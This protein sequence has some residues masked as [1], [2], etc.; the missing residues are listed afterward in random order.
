MLR[1]DAL[2]HPL[3]LHVLEGMHEVSEAA[4]DRLAG[5]QP[6]VTHRFLAALEHTGCVSAISGW[7]PQHITL[8]QG[9]DLVAA[10]PMY[11]K[12]HSY[13]EYVFDWAWAD[14]Y[15]TH[16]LEYYPKL[17]SAIPFT[18]VTGPRLLAT[19]D[20][21]KRQLVDMAI[22]YAE[23]IGASSFHCLFPE[24][25]DAEIL[26]N[27]GLLMRQGI[28]FHWANPGYGSFNDY[29]AA[30][31]HD[32]RKKIRQERRKSSAA[33]IR[34]RWL[35]GH[36]IT[37]DLWRFFT[38]CYHNTY[39]EHR[40]RP[41]LNLQCFERF[42]ETLAPHMVLI[43]AEEHG[44]SIA[45]AL[46]ILDG[47]KLYGRYWGAMNYRPG[48]HFE[49]CYYQAIE[50]CIAHGIETFE[51][52]AQGEHKLARGL[53]PVPTTSAHWLAHPAFSDA[54]DRYLRQEARGIS[55]YIDELNERQPF[56]RT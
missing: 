23:T 21:L 10:M 28:Q 52:G 31:N 3:T 56:K 16:G 4:W 40:A 33:G 41:Y 13:G 5:T 34:F 30:M 20:L 49:T 48:L 47:K 43:V 25:D 45:A 42:G 53:L 39:R 9:N 2:N 55:A 14:A 54:I 51:G 27:A 29:L 50:Y 32:K 19:D 11:A 18:P 44:Q 26:A 7:V 1:F 36:E 37:P 22:A 15:Q 38:A 17:L 8:W 24:P 46:N 6:F 35:Q 12:G